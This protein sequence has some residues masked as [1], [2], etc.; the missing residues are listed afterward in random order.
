MIRML[1]YRS[2]RDVGRFVLRLARWQIVTLL[3]VSLCGQPCPLNA[4]DLSYAE[5]I[6]EPFLDVTMSASVAGIITAQKFK[7]GDFVKEGDVILEL[8]KKLEELET[9]R[10]KL[11]MDN[12]KVDFEA[13][14]VL[15]KNTKAVSGEEREKKEVE[16]L[17]SVVEHDV[18]P[19]LLRRR[20]ILGH[21]SGII[22]E[23]I[24]RVGEACQ[25]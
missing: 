5:G 2:A 6:T 11:V 25:P 4:S 8:D 13:T 17:L 1:L 19:E 9:A 16:N 3:L 23:V 24:R 18:A 10:R 15:F 21:L 22:P 7:E 20:S 14:E 12:K